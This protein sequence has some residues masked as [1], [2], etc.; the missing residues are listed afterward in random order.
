EARLDAAEGHVQAALEADAVELLAVEEAD[1]PA[2]EDGE[3]EEP[4]PRAQRDHPA[5]RRGGHEAGGEIALAAEGGDPELVEA[6]AHVDPH[7]LELAARV[8]AARLIE[9][10]HRL[11]RAGL[12]VLRLAVLGLTVLRVLRLAILW[13]AVLRVL[14]LAVLWLAVLRLAV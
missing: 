1:A 11:L 6:A 7:P 14:R 10:L 9:L 3:V 13:L 4:R 5:G 8:V 2:Q 12:R